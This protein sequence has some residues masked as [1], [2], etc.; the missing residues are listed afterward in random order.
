[1]TIKERLKISRMAF[2]QRDARRITA[3][4]VRH[5]FRRIGFK[6]LK[7]TCGPKYFV[8]ASAD[9]AGFAKWLAVEA[10]RDAESKS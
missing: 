10:K 7:V 2:T 9:M 4:W 1:M 8:Y 6:K 3:E 5:G